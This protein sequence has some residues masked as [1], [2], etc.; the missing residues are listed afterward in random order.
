MKL[1]NSVQLGLQYKDRVHNAGQG[2]IFNL[3]IKLK[4]ISKV[5]S[6]YIFWVNPGNVSFDSKDLFLSSNAPK[7]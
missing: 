4:K 3:K 5:T 2:S 7:S 6:S 1:L